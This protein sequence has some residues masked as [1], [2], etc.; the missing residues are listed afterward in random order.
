MTKITKNISLVIDELIKGNPVALPTETV[1]GLA[2]NALNKDAVLNIFK[3]KKRPHFDPLIVHI[4]N[5]SEIYKYAKY[6]PEDVF[7][8]ADKF[9]PG[10]ITY[11][12]N[13]K[14][15]IHDLVTAGLKTVAIRIPS[16]PLIINVLKNIPFPLAAPS[17]NMF[18]R[19]SPTS[20]KDVLKELNGKINYVLEG[21]K[22]KIG[23][24][25]TVLGFGNNEVFILRPGF[26]T[27]S[28]IENTLGK[29]VQHKI[30]K[31]KI[32]SPGLLSSHY[33]PH[34]PLYIAEGN[35]DFDILKK[36]KAGFLDISKF[37]NINS[38]ASNLFSELRK[39][40]EKKYTFLI[41]EKIVNEGLGFAVNDRLQKASSGFIKMLNDELV[42]MKK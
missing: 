28:Q 22:S 17:A 39:M 21:G 31:T 25:S 36:L 32:N 26:I 2:A 3:I 35:I 33:A 16:H 14:N 34:T 4:K 42:I 7:K 37:K 10:P 8:L 38:L 29:K 15:N 41:V 12:I 5:I 27:K 20:A 24:E 11:V 13:K 18:G 30:F 40:D 1:Y 19:I 23:I 6:I 9:S